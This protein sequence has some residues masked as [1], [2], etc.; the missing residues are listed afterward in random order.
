MCIK[1]NNAG[2]RGIPCY[3]A[4]TCCKRYGSIIITDRNIV[5]RFTALKR[6]NVSVD[7]IHFAVFTIE[8]V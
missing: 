7:N 3:Y 6:I 2:E 8:A 4:V 1:S 5:T